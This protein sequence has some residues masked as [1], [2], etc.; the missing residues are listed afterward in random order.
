MS[1]ETRL[2]TDTLCN[3]LDLFNSVFSR[4]L[5]YFEGEDLDVMVKHWLAALGGLTDRDLA[6]AA[7]YWVRTGTRYP[8]PADLHE[9]HYLIGLARTISAEYDAA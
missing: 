9:C 7:C 4:E 2:S 5:P 1:T 8:T 6:L 3:A